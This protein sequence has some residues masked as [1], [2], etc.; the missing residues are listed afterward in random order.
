M[1]L[2][3]L[4]GCP[5]PLPFE[6]LPVLVAAFHKWT[7]R[8]D[9]HYRNKLSLY[10]LSCLSGGRLGSGGLVFP[11]G[12]KWVISSPD[13]GLIEQVVGGIVLDPDLSEHGLYVKDVQ[14][15]AEPT[16]VDGRRRFEFLS[17]IL[18]R[19][20]AAPGDRQ[21]MDHVRFDDPR[22][23]VLLTATLRNKL[24][25][26]GLDPTGVEV[27]FDSDYA[28]ASVSIQYYRGIG[29]RVNKCPVLITGTAE[30]QRFAWLVGV[31]NSTG[32][33]LG[34]LR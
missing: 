16:F 10:S 6:H 26:A 25:A 13:A 15:T 27:A 14:I 4:L 1:R 18:V 7:G 5:S 2:T 24:T 21:P 33:G 23:T 34:A 3:L 8:T 28:K 32:I 12:A 20:Q 30:Q 17:P 29:N 31:G 11:N 19:E 9:L 22:A